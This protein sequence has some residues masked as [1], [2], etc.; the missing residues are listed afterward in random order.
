M[1]CPEVFHDI[2]L[3]SWVDFLNLSAEGNGKEK[4]EAV[5]LILIL[6]GAEKLVKAEPLKQLVPVDEYLPMMFNRHPE[7]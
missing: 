7:M 1:P 2:H 6:N 4:E 3:V 5:C